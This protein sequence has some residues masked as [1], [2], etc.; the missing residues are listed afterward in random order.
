[1][2]KFLE[3]D[4]MMARAIQSHDWNASPIGPP[5]RWPAALKTTVSLILN[6]HFPQCIAWGPSLTTIPNDAFLPI[7]GDKPNPLGRPF[8]EAW[9]EAWSE[10]APIVDKA[11][12]GEPT[13][14]EDFPLVTNRNGYDEQA[15]FTFCYSPIRNEFGQI[16]G[17]LD[18]V[19]ETT[20]KVRL[21]ERQKVLAGELGHRLKNILTVVQAVASQTIRQSTDLKSA[22]EALAFRLAAFGRAADVLTDAQWEDADLHA[23]VDTALATHPALID[24]F[25]A[26]GPPIK[27]RAEIALALSLAFHELA[28]NATKYGAL[29]N[30]CGKINLS[31]SLEE[32][33]NGDGP[34]FKLTWAEIGGPPV[35]PPERRGFGSLMIERSL[36]S[37][38]RGE[39]VIDYRPDGLVFKIDAPLTGAQAEGVASG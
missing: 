24:R 8:S 6:S 14:L 15:H 5:D 25:T 1:M 12:A 26:D 3:G 35:T 17:M 4:G 22:N 18:T 37:Y 2:L 28:T 20:E 21:H 19:T 23:L 9:S 27:F 38:L 11:F 31:W 36:R 29:S 34:R 7:L 39:A 33:H 32:G 30:D 10:L 16:V 13:Y